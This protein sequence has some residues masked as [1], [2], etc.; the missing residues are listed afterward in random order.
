VLALRAVTP[1]GYMPAAQG[2][3]LLF[4][5]CPE[6]VPAEIMQAL[7][8]GGHHHHHG[9]SGDGAAATGDCPIGH[10]LSSAVTHD[11]DGV[12][13]IAPDTPTWTIATVRPAQGRRHPTYQSRAPPA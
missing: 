10:M 13:D 7:S 11:A 1:E 8:G 6:G 5:L 2:S 4:E 3:G 9:A 12:R